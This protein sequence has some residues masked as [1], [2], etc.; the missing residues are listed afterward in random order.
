M[1]TTANARLSKFSFTTNVLSKITY[2]LCISGDHID[3]YNI[4]KIIKHFNVH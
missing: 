4:I 3:Y 2:F 1:Q